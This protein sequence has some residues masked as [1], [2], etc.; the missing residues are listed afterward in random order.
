MPKE[1]KP[2]P[3]FAVVAGTRTEADSWVR[4]ISLT[5]HSLD[6]DDVEHPGLAA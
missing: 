2:G 6:R 5:L 1:S 4:R 3:I